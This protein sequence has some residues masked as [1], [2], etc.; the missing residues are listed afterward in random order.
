MNDSGTTYIE[1]SL[2]QGVLVVKVLATEMRDTDVCYAIRDQ[3]ID[4][5]DP[6]HTQ[7]AILDLQ[8][9]C[10]VGSIGLLGF[11]GMR[12]KIP[13]SRIIVCNLSDTIRE[14][15]VLCRLISAD[16]SSDAPF[17]VQ[18]TLQ[19]ALDCFNT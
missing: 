17:E 14:M 5:I 12:R 9:L 13:K 11:L 18:T 6:D 1:S 3:L 4:V 8:N 2:L 16:N 15:F 19:D 7:N 10:F